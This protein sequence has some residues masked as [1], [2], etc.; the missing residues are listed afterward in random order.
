[1][2]KKYF[3]R[4]RRQETGDNPPL[5]PPPPR[6]GEMDRERGSRSGRFVRMIFLPNYA[7]KILTF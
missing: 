2:L 6:R 1:M 7:P 4:G 5:A 3:S